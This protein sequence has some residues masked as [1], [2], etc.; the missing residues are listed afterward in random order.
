MQITIECLSGSLAGRTL[1]FNQPEIVLG[2]GEQQKRDVDFLD[3][4]MAVS[5]DHGLVFERD[6]RIY[7]KDQ[8]RGGTLAQ[9][10]KIQ[11]ATIE[12]QSGDE[13]QL[14]GKQG[15]VLKV[16]FRPPTIVDGTANPQTPSASSP[17]ATVLQPGSPPPPPKPTAD[18]TILQDI[19]GAESSSTPPP[20]ASQT[21]SPVEE[22]LE[23]EVQP[24]SDATVFQA[25]NN[26]TPPPQRP[27][28]NGETILQETPSRPPESVRSEETYFQRPTADPGSTISQG[29]PSQVE[30]TNATILQESTPARTIP[31]VPIILGLVAVAGAVGIWFFFLR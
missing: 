16:L 17:A 10:K 12:L 1:R 14:G 21:Q 13:L 9:G 26:P 3:T 15:P 20:E 2:R 30:N 23:E 27:I 25:S 29:N 7:Y 31:W 18:S 11:D 8:S 5:R 19:D 28:A 24:P 4:D 6:E 22:E